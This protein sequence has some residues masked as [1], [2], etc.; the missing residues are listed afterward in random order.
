[1]RRPNLGHGGP[2]PGVV[3]RWDRGQLSC[4]KPRPCLRPFGYSSYASAEACRCR[5]E[6]SV[7]FK[8]RQNAFPA[9]ACPRTL[10]IEL[11]H[12]A[13][14]DP[15]VGW[16]GVRTHTFPHIPPHLATR[17]LGLEQGIVPAPFMVALNRADHYIFILSFVLLLSSFF[18]F[19]R[20]IPAAADWMS[21]ILPHMV[22]RLSANLRCRSETCCTRLVK[23]QD[24]TRMWANA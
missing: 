24:A 20:L 1:M 3:L 13:T 5:K 16:G 17:R 11:D 2:R 9:G 4:L 23:I 14:P 6:R 19:H 15:V 21:A 8:I 18:F 22:W 7:A 10:R 12:L